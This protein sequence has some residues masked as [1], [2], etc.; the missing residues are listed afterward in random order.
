MVTAAQV[1]VA[2]TRDLKMCWEGTSGSS[3]DR[4]TATSQTRTRANGKLPI[5]HEVEEKD[6]LRQ[7]S[8]TLVMRSK[9]SARAPQPRRLIHLSPIDMA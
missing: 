2:R 1:V 8:S 6:A 7:P 9:R 5:H 3:R 4:P